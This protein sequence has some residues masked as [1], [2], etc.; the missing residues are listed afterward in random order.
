MTVASLCMTPATRSANATRLVVGQVV[1]AF[2]VVGV[3]LAQRLETLI[4]VPI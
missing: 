2:F 3:V 1:A 4:A